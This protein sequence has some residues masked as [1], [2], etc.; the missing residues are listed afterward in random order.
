M[1]GRIPDAVKRQRGTLQK[2]RVR[3]PKAI[4]SVPVPAPPASMKGA[5]RKKWLE[6]KAA[7]D[8]L[9]VYTDAYLEAFR[10]TVNACFMADEAPPGMRKGWSQEARAWMGRMGLDPASRDAITPLKPQKTADENE[11]PIFG[12]RGVVGGTGAS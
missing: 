6:L 3:Q 9:G 1:A 10:R 2:C 4:E 8:S 11:T 12:I 7:V 5:E